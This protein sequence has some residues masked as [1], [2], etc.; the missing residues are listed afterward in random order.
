MDAAEAGREA[1]RAQARQ[2]LLTH[3]PI[4]NDY[5]RVMAM[6]QAEYTGPIALA[7]PGLRYDLP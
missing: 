1:T 5:E 6:A 7:Q 3:I 2:L 4:E